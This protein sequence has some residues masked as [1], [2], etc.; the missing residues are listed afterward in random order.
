MRKGEKESE[1]PSDSAD[2]SADPRESGSGGPSSSAGPS[3]EASSKPSESS[4]PSESAGPFESA[5]ATPGDSVEQSEI[6]SPSPSE[7]GNP[8]ESGDPLNEASASLSS[9]AS[10][11]PSGKDNSRGTFVESSVRAQHP[12]NQSA[13]FGRQRRPSVDDSSGDGRGHWHTQSPR[14]LA[15][16]PRRAGDHAGRLGPGLVRIGSFEAQ[17]PSGEGNT[18]GG[19]GITSHLVKAAPFGA[20]YFQI[21]DAGL[22]DAFEKVNARASAFTV[23]A[24]RSCF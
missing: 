6:G 22:A 10:A 16:A 9:E 15:A 24:F 14:P 19:M 17:D 7:S 2:P 21:R 20:S 18:E 12:D 11:S 13:P 3:D 23:A 5:S 4:S 8:S 1:T